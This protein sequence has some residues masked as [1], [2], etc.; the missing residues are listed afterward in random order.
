MTT[1]ETGEPPGSDTAAAP[2]TLRQPV[3]YFLRLGVLGFGGPI[4]LADCTQKDL[5]ET[6]RWYGGAPFAPQLRRV[7]GATPMAQAASS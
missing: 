2:F 1:T 5:V 7:S 4:A 3:G 6:R